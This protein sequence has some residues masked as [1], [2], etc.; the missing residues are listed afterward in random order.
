[1]AKLV[2]VLY[3]M[4]AEIQ[5]RLYCPNIDLQEELESHEKLYEAIPKG[6]KEAESE[7][8]C[9]LDRVARIVKQAIKAGAGLS[10][11]SSTAQL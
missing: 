8:R 4:I 5:L 2:R 7:M 11:R 6:E 1:M 10:N 3:E 9:H